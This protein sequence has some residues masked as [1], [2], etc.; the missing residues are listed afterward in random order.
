MIGLMDIKI[1]SEGQGG[2]RGKPAIVVSDLV[3]FVQ[4]DGVRV[5]GKGRWRE[6]GAL[7]ASWKCEIVVVVLLD[8]TLEKHIS[9]ILFRSRILL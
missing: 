9:Y 3:V 2:G 1:S 7:W 8:D 5:E 6:N 4:G